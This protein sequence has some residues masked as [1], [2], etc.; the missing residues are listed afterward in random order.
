[1]TKE[2]METLA[3]LIISKL[4]TL[5]EELDENYFKKMKEMQPD[6]EVTRVDPLNIISF[7]DAQEALVE[8]LSV[9]LQEALEKENYELAAKLQ[10]RIDKL[11]RKK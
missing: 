7:T 11:K 5:Q 3:N 8:Q 9:N 10:S 4:K 1:M 6:W 2:E